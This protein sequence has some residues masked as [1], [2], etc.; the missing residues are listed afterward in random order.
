MARRRRPSRRRRK[1]MVWIPAQAG[2]NL[3]TLGDGTVF[4]SDLIPALDEDFFLVGIKGVWSIRDLTQGQD[5]IV[6]GVAHGDLS[7]TEIKEAL[8]AS[9]IGPDDII[10][11]GAQ[12]TSGPSGRRSVCGG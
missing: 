12:Q 11:R 9:M 4:L 6:V 10:A 1:G 7:V 2:F 5:P 3:S 8:D